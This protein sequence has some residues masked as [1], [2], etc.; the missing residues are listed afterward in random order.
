M[1]PVASLSIRQEK[2]LPSA[3]VFHAPCGR[4]VAVI[5]REEKSRTARS[6]SEFT[7]A[8]VVFI[9]VNEAGKT[10]AREALPGRDPAPVVRPRS[11]LGARLARRDGERAHR[12]RHRVLRQVLGMGDQ[13]HPDSARPARVLL[14]ALACFRMIVRQI[15]RTRTLRCLGGL[16]EDEHLPQFT[17]SC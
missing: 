16:V 7:V 2:F 6:L 4:L 11:A 9:A 1:Y 17:R 12:R 5:A 13:P 8:L 15:L 14:E 10:R 3:G